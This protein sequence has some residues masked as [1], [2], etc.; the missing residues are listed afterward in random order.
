MFRLRSLRFP[1]AS[2]AN[3]RR[4]VMLTDYV[5]LTNGAPAQKIVGEVIEA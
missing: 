5:N 4:R 1:F 2:L 3:K